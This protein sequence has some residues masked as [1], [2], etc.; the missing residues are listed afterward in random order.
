M[1][2]KAAVPHAWLA[3]NSCE[4]KATTFFTPVRKTFFVTFLLADVFEARLESLESQKED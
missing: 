4:T 2:G 3:L 1:V